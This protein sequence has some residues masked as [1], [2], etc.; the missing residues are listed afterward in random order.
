VEIAGHFAACAECRNAV[1]ALDSLRA[2]DP[3]LPDLPA[4]SARAEPEAPIWRWA[5]YAVPLIVIFALAV[6][7]PN[8]GA[9]LAPHGDL[10]QPIVDPEQGILGDWG[11]AFDPDPGTGAT[12][13][14]EAGSQVPGAS[15]GSPQPSLAPGIVPS[16]G[17]TP[18]GVGDPS[19]A[20]FTT[21]PGA[22]AP[23]SLP[24]G[25]TPPPSVQASQP[26]EPTSPP[27][28]DPTAPPPPPVTPEP[29]PPPT[30]QPTPE[31]TP[32]PTPEP[33]PEPNPSGECVDGIDN[34]GDL[35]IDILDPGCLLGLRNSES[36]L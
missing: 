25:V 6:L 35:L 23:A 4:P 10:F 28:S 5:R 26:G 34:D 3:T 16:A 22:S 33:T 36:L 24:P 13:T 11:S 32:P 15:G 30:P 12:P 1:N 19:G 21:A 8:I 7:R 20:P 27:S 14:D 17:A 31:P 18:G 2:I 29:T 9:V